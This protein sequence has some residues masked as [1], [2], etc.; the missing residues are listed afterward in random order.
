MSRGAGL[1]EQCLGGEEEEDMKSGATVG[2]NVVQ[3][4][5]G[6]GTTS[7]ILPTTSKARDELALAKHQSNVKRKECDFTAVS[8]LQQEKRLWSSVEAEDLSLQ[9][10]AQKNLSEEK[11]A[12]LPRE[13]LP[14][15]YPA[16]P[17]QESR[18]SNPTGCQGN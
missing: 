14:L 9:V 5:T 7:Q 15:P 11:R 13:A 16:V 6:G 8:Q 18:C 17:V 1:W 2:M 3:E 12:G 4:K 10:S